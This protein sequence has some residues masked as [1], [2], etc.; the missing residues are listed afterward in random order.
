[1]NI[2]VAEDEKRLAEALRYL[3]ERENYHVDVVHDGQQALDFVES[4]IS[5]SLFIFDIMMPR[6]NGLE[7]LGRIR[8][9]A[10]DTPVLMLTALSQTT[11]KVKG[12]DQGADDYMTKPFQPD[13]L[14][15]R[16]R[17]LTRRK[18]EVVLDILE[19]GDLSLNL[20]SHY[21]S[22]SNSMEKHGVRLSEKEFEVL[23]VLMR[24]P[25]QV[26]SKDQLIA[27]VWGYD[28][29][30]ENNNAEAYISFLRKKLRHLTS[31]T[32]IETIRGLGYTLT[33]SPLDE[34]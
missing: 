5:Y 26:I 21:L 2:L 27:D 18:G 22:S 15:A 11:D 30:V 8:K 19:Y 17:A 9:H 12:L 29:Y 20:N 14:L 16:V 13:E 4:Q 1:M 33:I 23:S 10:V 25:N 6:L 28:S 3:L 34:G 31:I 32:A 7:L 24:H